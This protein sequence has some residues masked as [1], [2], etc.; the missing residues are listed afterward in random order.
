ML[1]LGSGCG[2]VAA[3]IAATRRPREVLAL[4]LQPDLAA[5]A[6]RNAALNR[7][8]NLHPLEAD[9]RTRTIPGLA[10]GSFDWVVANPPYRALGC[11]RESPNPSR[12]LARGAAGA[13]LRDFV[14]AA[15][16]YATNGGRIGM[17]FTAP[18]TAELVAELKT[19]ALEPKRLRF[20][21]PDP[22]SPATMILVEARKRAGVEVRVEPPLIVWASPGVYTAEA[23]A[24]LNGDAYQSRSGR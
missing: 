11:G 7:L 3:M 8:A 18:R 19:K 15:A 14:A 9:L 1:E 23:R 22:Q 4:E 17:I 13:N 2:V 21:H 20:V 6:R 10:A 16:R 5:L 12:R 24:I